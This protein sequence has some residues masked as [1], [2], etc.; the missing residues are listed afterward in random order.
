MLL[1]ATIAGFVGTVFFPQ[2]WAEENTIPKAQGISGP[3]TDNQVQ[4][5]GSSEQSVIYQTQWRRLQAVTDAAPPSAPVQVA[6]ER[7]VPAPNSAS[8]SAVPLATSSGFAST[9]LSCSDQ[10]AAT[11]PH[12]EEPKPTPGPSPHPVDT[13]IRQVS[14][15]HSVPLEC[16]G[17]AIF[18]EEELTEQ[19]KG[20]PVL[21]ALEDS[22]RRRLSAR[23]SCRPSEL[24]VT[25]QNDR[26]I[27]IR[28]SAHSPSEGTKMA[29]K[30]L[31][32]PELEPFQILLDVAIVH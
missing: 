4:N 11:Q 24:Q 2:V 6:P 19:P 9:R 26:C 13:G 32:T 1:A 27:R 22:I 16:Y 20:D 15:V 29:N 30:I 5:P 17:E 14:V 31:Q 3:T 7:P 28:V 25:A 12:L 23:C 18:T 21:T 10:K 8:S